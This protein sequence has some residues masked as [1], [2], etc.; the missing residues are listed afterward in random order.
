MKLHKIH[1]PKKKAFWYLLN[2]LF[3]GLFQ[4]ET[5][6][7]IGTKSSGCIHEFGLNLAKFW[8]NV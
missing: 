6:F 1:V 7:N 8:T 3:L 5:V 2:D 4:R